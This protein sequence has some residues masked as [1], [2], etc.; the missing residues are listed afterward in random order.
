MKR[1]WISLAILAL[2][3]AAALG[4]SWYLGRLTGQLTGIL[5]TAQQYG[6]TEHWA[7]ARRETEQAEQLWH[8][9]EGY[10][11]TVLRHDETDAVASGFREV[12]ELLEWQEEAEYTSANARLIEN[13]RLL[14]EMEKLN[15]QNLL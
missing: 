10:L 7:Q 3:F 1:L 9:A 12:K 6:E 13:I 11:Y 2:L 14:S 15:L 5:S 8:R 4:N